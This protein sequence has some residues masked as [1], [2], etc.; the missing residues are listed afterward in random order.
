MT[1][2]TFN[3]DA[4]G[5]HMSDK[6]TDGPAYHQLYAYCLYVSYNVLCDGDLCM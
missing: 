5:I 2:I 6:I 4:Q 3:V 1:I